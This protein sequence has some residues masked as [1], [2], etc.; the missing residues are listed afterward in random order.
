MLL[1]QLVAP[2]ITGFATEMLFMFYVVVIGNQHT[3]LK[4]IHENMKTTWSTTTST[5]LM[6]LAATTA[7]ATSHMVKSAFENHQYYNSG[8]WHATIIILVVHHMTLL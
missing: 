6:W 7:I 3:C 4:K 8:M 5:L 2:K 1:E